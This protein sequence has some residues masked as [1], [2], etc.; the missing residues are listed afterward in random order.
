M[1]VQ[2]ARGGPV[3]LPAVGD[4][5]RPLGDVVAQKRAQRL[6]GGVGQRDHPA[7]P[8]ALGLQALDGDAHEHLL[9]LRAPAGQPWFLTADVGLIDLHSSLKPLAARAHEHRAQAVQ[10]RPGGLVGAD[11]Q[12]ALQAQR[13]DPVLLAGEQPARHEPHGQRRARL[14]EDRARRHRRA[15]AALRALIAPVREL[16]GTRV[17]ATRTDEPLRPPQPLQEVQ[18]VGILGK[19]RL[20]LTHR[21]RVVHAG[22]R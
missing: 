22:P 10:H 13:R 4:H 15:L 8:E 16:P 17:G 9:A 5:P 7:A 21:P 19:P 12:R 11:L 6:P 20:E 2:I 18:A 1:H 3:G 14:V